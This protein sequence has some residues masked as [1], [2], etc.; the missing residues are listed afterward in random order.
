MTR[1]DRIIKILVDD[2]IFIAGLLGWQDINKYEPVPLQDIYDFKRS[3]T[4]DNLSSRV[5]DE[6]AA[7]GVWLDRHLPE[8]FDITDVY[9]CQYEARGLRKSWDKRYPRAKEVDRLVAV[10]RRAKELSKAAVTTSGLTSKMAYRVQ[11]RLNSLI[12][13]IDGVTEDNTRSKQNRLLTFVKDHWDVIGSWEVCGYIASKYHFPDEEIKAF[14]SRLPSTYS[15]EE[16][17]EDML[18]VCVWLDN[19]THDRFNPCV[20]KISKALRKAE[21]MFGIYA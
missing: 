13:T 14:V 11:S 1:Q 3:L 5:D 7:A 16:V 10:L 2:D 21:D 6:I 20:Y 4:M 9:N 12:A 19:H 8:E 17:G 18:K 15:P